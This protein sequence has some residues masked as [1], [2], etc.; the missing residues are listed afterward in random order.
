LPAY[1][2]KHESEEPKPRLPKVLY[3]YRDINNSFHLGE[4]RN[5]NYYLNPSGFWYRRVDLMKTYY[6]YILKCIDQSYYTGITNNL[7]R[8]L[9][10]HHL[11]ILPDSYTASRRPVELMFY[12]SFNDVN[13]AIAFEKQVKGWSRKKKQAL[14]NENWWKLKELSMCGNASNHLYYSE[15][16]PFDSAQ[17]DKQ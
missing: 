2:N 1:E 6:V 5:I 10:E 3:K 16:P 11:G 15:R 4:R 7:E 8:R 17:G 14:I 12:E 13:R 9:A